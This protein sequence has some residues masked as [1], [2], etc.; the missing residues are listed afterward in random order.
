MYYGIFNVCT[1]DNACDCPRGCT[2]TVR[3][4]ALKVDSGRKIPCRTGEL[5]LRRR[6][7]G[8]MLYQLSHIATTSS[9]LYLVWFILTPSIYLSVCLK[10]WR[11]YLPAKASN[12]VGTGFESGWL[13]MVRCRLTSSSSESGV[14]AQFLTS[15]RDQRHTR[16]LLLAAQVNDPSTDGNRRIVRKV[17]ATVLANFM[18]R[19]KCCFTLRRNHIMM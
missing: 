7:A 12:G 4:S 13:L 8:P 18:N 5:N 2:D 10:P 11:W 9:P 15:G 16:R 19:S 14:R 6:Y 3:E 17:S 1:Y